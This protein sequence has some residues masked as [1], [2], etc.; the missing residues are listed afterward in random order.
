MTRLVPT[1]AAVLVGLSG[2][3]SSEGRLDP[4]QSARDEVPDS[5]PKVQP[6]EPLSAETYPEG[7]RIAGRAAERALTY[8]RGASAL[9]VAR[10]VGTSD[11]G[12]RAIAEVI[13]PAID[14]EMRSAGRVVYAQLS[15]LTE[16]SLGAMVVT[17]QRLQDE[18]GRWRSLTRVLDVRLLREGGTWRLEQIAS[19]GGSPVDRPASLGESAERVLDHPGIEL[20]DSARWDVYRGEVDP[21]LLEVLASAA[22]DGSD[23]SIAVLQSGHPPNVWATD[24]PSA[25]SMGLAA[26]IWAVD[27]TP[28]I[29]QRETGTP[30]YDLAAA[31]V[32]GGAAQV[33]S[34]WILGA[35]GAGSFADEV[36]QDHIHLQQAPLG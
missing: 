36:H 28:V 19:I 15:G 8:A 16:T 32:S 13:G 18:V 7:K 25:H 5:R 4:A 11:V 35:G 10:F 17:E 24:R 23:L 22:D 3:A 2:C 20:S 12:E 21:A 1:L 30:A 6:Y 31:L 14:P 27:G 34:P 33:G 29:E 9:E 26:D